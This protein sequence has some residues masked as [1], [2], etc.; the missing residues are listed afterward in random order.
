MATVR[1]NSSFWIQA[2]TVSGAGGIV[3]GP[4]TS[5]TATTL[6]GSNTNAVAILNI[7]QG[8]KETF[9]SFTDKST[10]AA[11]L[12][13]SFTLNSGTNSYNDAT[14][15]ASVR[16]I[17]GKCLTPTA[18]VSSGT[19]TW[20]LLHRNTGTTSLTDKGAL[21]G[22]VGLIGSGAELQLSTVNIVNGNY[23][24]C[25]GFPINFNHNWTV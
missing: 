7:Y 20:F 11:D 17:I 8:T 2:L 6:S 21:I 12:L 3:Y 4:T 13:I 23:Y 25:N 10:R 14:G 9:P 1:I 22:D 5:P 19:A 15:N 18:A 24:R 16:Y